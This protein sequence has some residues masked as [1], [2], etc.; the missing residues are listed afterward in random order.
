MRCC[1]AVHMENLSLWLFGC[2]LQGLVG[3]GVGVGG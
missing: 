1:L 3:V 2:K